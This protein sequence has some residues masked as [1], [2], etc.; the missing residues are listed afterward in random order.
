M[1]GEIRSLFEKL[2]ISLPSSDYWSI[3]KCEV[4]FIRVTEENEDA[5]NDAVSLG[6]IRDL[7]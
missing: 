7:I 3:P 5:W 2:P 4:Q 1:G 6:V